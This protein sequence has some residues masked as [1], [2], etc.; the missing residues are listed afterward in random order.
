VERDDD[1]EFHYVPSYDHQRQK[2]K[3][4]HNMT[5]AWTTKMAQRSSQ[6]DMSGLVNVEVLEES[7]VL[8]PMGGGETSVFE[9]FQRSTHDGSVDGGGGHVAFEVCLPMHCA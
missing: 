2:E 7:G 8:P 9:E 6:R 1:W 5:A 4:E 3:M